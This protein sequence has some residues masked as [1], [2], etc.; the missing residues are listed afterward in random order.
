M[1]PRERVLMSLNHKEPPQVAVD[2]GGHRSSGIAAMAYQGLR[3]QLGLEA[4]PTYV[5][6]IIQQLAI[7][8]DD[9]IRVR[10]AQCADGAGEGKSR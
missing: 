8:H 2:F 1:T 9:V 10:D 6:D 4:K 7:I 5:Y 3:R